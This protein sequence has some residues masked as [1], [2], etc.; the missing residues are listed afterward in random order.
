M[1]H[2][3][4]PVLT[5]KL[6]LVAAI[7][8]IAATT[9]ARDARAAG[10]AFTTIDAP[11][12]TNTYVMAN[13]ASGDVVGYYTDAN[14][15]YH[16]FLLRGGAFTTLD[17]PGADVA[18]T[19][20]NTIND[21]GDVAGNYALKSPAPAGNVHGF[22]RTK[23]GEWS[24]Q[25]YPEGTHIMAGGAY[26]VLA[27]GTVVGCYHDGSPITAMFGY[28]K[29]PGGATSFN[30]PPGAP[31]AMH[32]GVT[33]DGKTVVGA[34]LLGK[35]QPDNWH[36]YVFDS[37]NVVSFDV[38]GKAG[39]QA[40]GISPGRSVVGVYKV[41]VGTTWGAHGFVADT[42]GSLDPTGWSFALVDV[43]ESTQ[44]IVRSLNARGEMAGYYI[45][46]G[47]AI[48]GFLATA[49]TTTTPGSNAGLPAS[50]VSA[51]PAPLP[52]STGAG[53]ALSGS[54]AGNN[55]L[56]ASLASSSLAALAFVACTLQLRRKGRSSSR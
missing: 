32:Y 38:P 56:L 34:Y 33:P 23:A 45:D 40:L 47:G 48:H 6:L 8:L 22:L 42:R 25:D 21:A 3:W 15:V 16:G 54:S 5:K 37:G 4:R 13:N 11:N 29:G 53:L 52:P 51:S 43:P 26:G 50:P 18:W 28:A 39:T 17:F 7:A 44:T 24:T 49:A 12:S 10:S 46:A 27:D 55:L 2:Q 1:A 14:K 20:A 9:P 36:G 35:N 31:F 41:L 19:Q 30:Y